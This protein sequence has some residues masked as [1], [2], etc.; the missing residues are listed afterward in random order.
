MLEGKESV[1]IEVAR[2]AM[3]ANLAEQPL[4]L[5]EFELSYKPPVPVN[6]IF[7]ALYIRTQGDRE[8]RGCIGRHG[9]YFET[10]A[11][12]VADCTVLSATQDPR[13]GS[14][15]EHEI[16]HLDIEISLLS[17]PGKV[18]DL[19]EINPTIHGLLMHSGEKMATVLP[20]LIG[21][22]SVQQQITILKEKAGLTPEDQYFLEKFTC[23]KITE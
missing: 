17:R 19:N 18:F 7:V 9:R 5:Q 10:I 2:R 12:E 3:R 4:E 16:K 8:L 21:V 6:G 1:L 22:H 14:I 11:E 15:E 23:Y 20:D 13:Y